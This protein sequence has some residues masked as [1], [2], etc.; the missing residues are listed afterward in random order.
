MTT[1][2]RP[3]KK[4]GDIFHKTLKTESGDVCEA[5][6]EAVRPIKN[7]TKSQIKNKVLIIFKEVDWLIVWLF[8]Q[9]PIMFT[10]RYIK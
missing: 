2:D 6:V 7:L 10:W 8:I 4:L 9:E 1:K 3:R 5:D